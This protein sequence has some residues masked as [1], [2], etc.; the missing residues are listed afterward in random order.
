MRHSFKA[1]LGA[2]LDLKQAIKL[3]PDQNRNEW[4]AMHSMI[5][6]A[7]LN[8]RIADGPFFPATEMYNTLNVVTN[9]VVEC[10]TDKSCPEMTAGKEYPNKYPKIGTFELTYIFL[11]V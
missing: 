3:P 2:G 8:A 9:L 5:F 6:L 7:I 1:S 10:C 4:L 11:I